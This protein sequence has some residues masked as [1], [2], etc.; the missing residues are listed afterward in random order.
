MHF[1]PE[2]ART[3]RRTLLRWFARHG[4]RTLPWQKNRSPYRVWLAEIMLQQ[5]RVTAVLPYFEAFTRKFPTVTALAAATEDQVLH[6]WSGLG[7][8]ARAR[9]LH[10]CARLVRERHGGRFPR[11]LEELQA[12]PGIGRS[13]AGAILAAAFGRRGVILDG[14]A[15]RVLARYGAVEGWPGCSRTA[16]ELWHLAEHFT[17]HKHCAEYNQA[18]MDLG[19]AICTPRPDCPRCP[20]RR[21]CAARL[22]GRQRELPAPRP[23]HPLP[24]KKAYFWLIC[25]PAGEV[26]LQKRPGQGLWGG[27]WSPPQTAAAAHTPPGCAGLLD[28][29]PESSPGPVLHH[30]FSHFQLEI[31]P[32]HVRLPRTPQTVE[33]PGNS[34]WY[35]PRAPV[36][37]GLAAPVQR[38]LQALTEETRKE[39]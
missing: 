26:L 31:H 11:R 7:Y 36:A 34:L 32:L 2:D 27:L 18:I 33:E 22:Q 5:T 14:N 15:K 19:A 25:N 9:N 24:R 35:N 10:R 23:R 16:T 17:A 12:L 29:A 20:L 4:R 37:L 6:E 38:L 28:D 13:T 39:D 30:S 1:S 3:F 21:R 8:Y